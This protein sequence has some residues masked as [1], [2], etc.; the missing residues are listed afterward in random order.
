LFADPRAATLPEN[1]TADPS[2]K[3]VP[4]VSTL[5]PGVRP[6]RRESVYPLPNLT[7]LYNVSLNSFYVEARSRDDA[8][9]KAVARLRQSPDTAVR[10]IAPA[11]AGPKKKFSE[12]RSLITGK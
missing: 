11:D 7:M 2:G 1:G 8:F 3:V 6:C 12:I 4:L 9:A 10:Y 5:L